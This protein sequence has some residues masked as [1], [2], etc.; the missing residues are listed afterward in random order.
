MGEG[1]RGKPRNELERLEIFEQLAAEYFR[2]VG[3]FE[4]AGG[5]VPADSIEGQRRQ[6][7]ELFRAALLRKFIVRDEHVSL[8]LVVR[9]LRLCNYAADTGLAEGA[10]AV[11]ALFT[12]E[13]V[14][15]RQ[16]DIPGPGPDD[17]DDTFED[18]L[19]GRLLHGDADRFHRSEWANDYQRLSAAAAR[20]F[21]S[22]HALRKALDVVSY[23]LAN[24]LLRSPAAPVDAAGTE[25]PDL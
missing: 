2:M 1:K 5:P 19:Y 21:D 13:M 15:G 7:V 18:V 25:E 8:K 11:A 14:Q 17:G 4:P 12:A 10:D 3:L 6:W 9:A 16:H 24:G 20:R 23:G 22:E